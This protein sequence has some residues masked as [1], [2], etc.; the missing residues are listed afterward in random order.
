MKRRFAN[1]LATLCD[2]GRYSVALVRVTS[3]ASRSGSAGDNINV[4]TR[5]AWSGPDSASV[6]WWAGK[7]TAATLLAGA[8]TL[9][10]EA[11]DYARRF[12][13]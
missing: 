6:H 2:C 1:Q 8:T 13:S 12:R 3:L 10:C 4:S 11:Q 5:S 7:R 9:C